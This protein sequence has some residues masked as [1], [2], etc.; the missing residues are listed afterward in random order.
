MSSVT[1]VAPIEATL[2]G[3]TPTHRRHLR[4]RRPKVVLFYNGIW[5]MLWK[6]G[7]AYVYSMLQCLLQSLFRGGNAFVLHGANILWQRKC[8]LHVF[9]CVCIW[10]QLLELHLVPHLITVLVA[11][12]HSSGCTTMEDIIEVPSPDDGAQP[13]R[14]RPRWAKGLL[15]PP[16]IPHPLGRFNP[17]DFFLD[18]VEAMPGMQPGTWISWE[19]LIAQVARHCFTEEQALT[20]FEN[21]WGLDVMEGFHDPSL[22]YVRVVAVVV[23]TLVG[24][25]L[26]HYRHLC[27]RAQDEQVARDLE[28]DLASTT[29]LF[30]RKKATAARD[31]FV[32]KNPKEARQV[33]TSRW[34]A[35]RRA[36]ATEVAG[37]TWLPAS[38]QGQQGALREGCAPSPTN[39]RGSASLGCLTRSSRPLASRVA[40]TRWRQHSSVASVSAAWWCTTAGGRRRRP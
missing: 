12:H 18:I 5:S 35:L 16:L 22:E 36:C 26:L 15:G 38:A 8:L 4:G 25:E 39:S 19:T 30:A 21:W 2:R 23:E 33:T 9:E 7:N 13:I 31:K 28:Q 10:A 29:S 27:L 11:P 20:A 24:P 3:R 34:Q 37:F 6:G 40:R 32:C 1:A 14:K 17:L